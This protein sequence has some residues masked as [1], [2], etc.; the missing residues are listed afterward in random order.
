MM[1]SPVTQEAVARRRA[2]AAPVV[3]IPASAPVYLLIIS[4][5]LAWRYS[6]STRLREASAIALTTC[7]GIIDPESRV[8]D[9]AALTMVLTPNLS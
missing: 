2:E 6:I 5:A 7:G 8:F 3:T 4:L 1:S 9:P